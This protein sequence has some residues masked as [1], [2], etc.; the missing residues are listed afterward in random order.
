MLHSPLLHDCVTN[1]KNGSIHDSESKQRRQRGAFCEGFVK[2]VEADC[3]VCSCRNVH[4]LDHVLHG[5][6]LFGFVRLVLSGFTLYP[7]K[8]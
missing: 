2:H 4:P 6:D 8:S 1:L 5:L 3:H 7:N